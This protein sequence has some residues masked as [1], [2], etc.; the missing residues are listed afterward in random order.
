[1]LIALMMG[2]YFAIGAPVGRL[3]IVAKSCKQYGVGTLAS[4]EIHFLELLLC[5]S[6]V[7]PFFMIP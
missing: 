3:V 4:V 7:A 1:M 5:M 6:R 2:H